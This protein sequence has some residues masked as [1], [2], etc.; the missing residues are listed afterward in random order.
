MTETKVTFESSLL[1]DKSRDRLRISNSLSCNDGE[2]P[3][4]DLHEEGGCGEKD[5][6]EREQADGAEEAAAYPPPCHV[7]DNVHWGI[8][9]LTEEEGGVRRGDWKNQ[10]E[11]NNDRHYVQK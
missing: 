2:N 4:A 7:V 6:V 11:Q 1:E 5:D 10:N 9:C 3:P 8:E